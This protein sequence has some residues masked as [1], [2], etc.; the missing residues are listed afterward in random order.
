MHAIWPEIDD[1]TNK[2]LLVKNKS[3]QSNYVKLN[4]SL[5]FQ[6]QQR[7]SYEKLFNQLLSQ[8]KACLDSVYQQM[9]AATFIAAA[10][11]VE[12]SVAGTCKAD[13]EIVAHAIACSADE[14]KSVIKHCLKWLK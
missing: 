11:K 8:I 10:S 6:Q 14:I 1:L 3:T 5:A 2:L 12:A 9:R 4:N 13:L 7:L